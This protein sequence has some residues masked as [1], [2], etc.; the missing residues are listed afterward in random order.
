MTLSTINT[1]P[2]EKE[3]ARGAEGRKEMVVRIS[4]RE[5][6]A[7]ESDFKCVDRIPDWT[8][9]H[10]KT[11]LQFNIT[12][13]LLQ[14]VTRR[15]ICISRGNARSSAFSAIRIARGSART[16]DFQLERNENPVKSRRRSFRG[17][18]VRS[19]DGKHANYERVTVKLS[20]IISLPL[21]SLS[22]VQCQPHTPRCVSARNSYDMLYDLT[23]PRICRC[24]LMR[25]QGA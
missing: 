3:V 20:R 25:I 10:T 23:F 2:R 8:T 21:S 17:L 12:R 14:I 11:Q 19:P 7:R 6:N 22:T 18:S 4:A 13:E 16:R 1:S 9:H 15:G 5:W 24:P